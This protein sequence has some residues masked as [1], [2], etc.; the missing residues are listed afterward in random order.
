MLVALQCYVR[1]IFAVSAAVLRCS[2]YCWRCR[3][4]LLFA[5]VNAATVLWRA[6][7]G[8]LLQCSCRIAAMRVRQ[9]S[10]GLYMGILAYR[11]AGLFGCVSPPGR[12]SW[13]ACWAVGRMVALYK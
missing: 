13:K 12:L 4:G 11:T 8:G 7:C 9:F 10:G 5:I 3:S 1:A 2:C 6:C